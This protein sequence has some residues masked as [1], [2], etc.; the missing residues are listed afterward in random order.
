MSKELKCRY[1]KGRLFFGFNHRCSERVLNE[2]FD[3]LNQQRLRTIESL[4]WMMMDMK[5]KYNEQ[6]GTLDE[7]VCSEYS[8][9]LQKAIDLLEEL[10]ANKI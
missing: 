5:H 8:P 2:Y 9:K 10:K 3:K 7:D 1:C 6:K 4:E